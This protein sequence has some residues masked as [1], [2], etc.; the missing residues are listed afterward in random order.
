[1]F[2]LAEYWEAPDTLILLT[3]TLSLV[4]T[5][6]TAVWVCALVNRLTV[7]LSTPKEV[8]VGAWVSVLDTVAWTSSSSSLPPVSVAVTVIVSKVSPKL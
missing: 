4:T 5:V 1:M 3:P 2:P 7:A 6:N 8:I